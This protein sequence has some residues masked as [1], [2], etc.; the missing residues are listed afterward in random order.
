MRKQEI[1]LCAINQPTPTESGVICSYL[2]QGVNF[3]HHW[4]LH[5]LVSK[6]ALGE[7]PAALPGPLLHRGL[8]LAGQIGVRPGSKT[9]SCVRAQ[10]A[11]TQT[12][13]DL[14]TN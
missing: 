3:L 6:Q 13:A 12:E 2:Q 1:W 14:M 7:K 11:E 4:K 5:L 8:K 10:L 9:E